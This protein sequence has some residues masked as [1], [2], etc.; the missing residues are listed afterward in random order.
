MTTP[1]S[2]EN[3]T[4]ALSTAD[5]AAASRQSQR[6]NPDPHE[7]DET[8][9]EQ[10]TLDRDEPV[11]AEA[12]MPV[13]RPALPNLERWYRDLCERAAYREHVVGA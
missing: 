6:V 8:E 4:R 10:D 13:E 7:M 11:K 12:Q 5:L 2:R 9:L 3:S 1:T